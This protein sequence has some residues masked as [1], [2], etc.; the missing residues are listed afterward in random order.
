MSGWHEAP[1]AG[2]GAAGLPSG[3]FIGRET[4]RGL[5]R[6]ALAEA[7]SRGWRELV[8][9]DADFSDWPLG[10]RAVVDALTAWALSGQRLTLLARHYD[11]VLR[12]HPRFVIWRRQ[13]AHKIDARALPAT[14]PSEIPSALWTPGWVLLRLDVLRSGGFCSAETQRRQ[15]LREAL[16]DWLARSSVAFPTDTL[17]L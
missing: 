13:W 10:E 12:Q 3:P 17:G 2:A 6:Q 14:N 15:H 8:L 1:G 5:L 16:D 4:F 11:A 7:A 9:A